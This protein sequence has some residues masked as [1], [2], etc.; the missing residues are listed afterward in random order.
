MFLG[1]QLVFHAAVGEH[2][3]AGKCRTVAA[4]SGDNLQLYI[5]PDD[6]MVFTAGKRAGQEKAAPEFA[7]LHAAV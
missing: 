1:D 4:C 7:A 6:V 5:D 3:F 2:L